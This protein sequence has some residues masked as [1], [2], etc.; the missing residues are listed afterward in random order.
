MGN[1]KAAEELQIKVNHADGAPMK[2]EPI[3]VKAVIVHY[4]RYGSGRGR[5][6]LGSSTI[7]AFPED[8]LQYVDK[9]MG[10]GKVYL[11]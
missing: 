5:S 4:F 3:G 2:M 7:A 8:I 9:V 6:P 11:R 1:L 10:L